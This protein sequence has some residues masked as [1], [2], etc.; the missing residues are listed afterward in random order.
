MYKEFHWEITRIGMTNVSSQGAMMYC[1]S[2]HDVGLKKVS[3]KIIYDS[4]DI[5]LLSCFDCTIPAIA[6]SFRISPHY[7][8]VMVSKYSQA[9]SCNSET[10]NALH[11]NRNMSGLMQ[12]DLDL[13]GP[14]RANLY[15][16]CLYRHRSL[17]DRLDRGES[18]KAVA[19]T[20]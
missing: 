14:G 20:H 19:E 8:W 4:H 11:Q 18:I 12:S 9:W 16:V 1:Q 7:K 17:R 3:L 15:R 5:R 2:I 13:T 10:K 6:C